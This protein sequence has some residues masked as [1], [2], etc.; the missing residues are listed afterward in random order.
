MKPVKLTMCAF[1]PYPDKKEVDLS[2]FGGCGL[3]LVTGDTGAGKTTIFDAISFALYGEASGTNRES[4]MFRSDF[5]LPETKTYV[6]LEFLYRGQTYKIERSPKYMKEKSRGEGT[7]LVNANATLIMPDSRVITGN[8][9]VNDEVKALIGIDKNQ[10]SQIAMIAQGD[11]LKLLLSSTDER[12]KIFRKVFNT[13][14][15]LKFQ[16]ELKLKAN[17]LKLQYEDLSKSILQYMNGIIC[18]EDS[19]LYLEIKELMTE[20]NINYLSKANELLDN[21]ICEDEI[22]EEKEKIFNKKIQEEITVQSTLITTAVANNSRL[23]RLTNSN[24][25]LEELEKLQD[26]YKRKKIKLVL[27]ENALYHIKPIADELHKS[28]KQVND[29]NISIS[30]HEEF[31]KHR[32]I[33]LDNLLNVYENEKLKEPKLLSLSNEITLVKNELEIYKD[34]E[35]LRKESDIINKQLYEKS[36]LLLDKK[37]KK[38]NI[39]NMQ[40]KIQEELISLKDI[41]VLAEQTKKQ[42]EDAYSLSEQLNQLKDLFFELEKDKETLISAQKLFLKSHEIS[43]AKS[44]EYEK[45]EQSFL[46]GQAGIIAMKLKDNIPCPVCGSIDHPLPAKITLAAPTEEELKKAK[47]ELL[48]AKEQA[49]KL[50]EKSSN[51]KVKV[52]AKIEAIIKYS[53]S[54]FGKIEINEIPELLFNETEKTNIIL[55]KTTKKLVEIRKKIEYK[56]KCELKKTEIEKLLNNGVKI[57]ETLEKEIGDLKV[58]QS[59]LMSRLDTIKGKIKFQNKEEAEEYIKIKLMELNNL[60]TSLENSEKQYNKCNGEIEKSK[61]VILDLNNRLVTSK[62]EMDLVIEK[63]NVTLKSRGFTNIDHYNDMLI[64]EDNI[65]SLKKDI[66]N[67][68]N[69][70]N[71]VKIDISNLKEETKNTV[72]INIEDS[73]KLKKEFEEQKYKSDK[74][75]N[76]IFSRL[77][78]NKKVRNEIKLKQKEMDEIEVEYLCY[79]NLSDTANGNLSGKQKI[80]FEYY[81]QSTYFN[82]II[83]EANRRF[84]YMTNGRFKLIIKEEP[85]NFRSQTGLELDVIDNYTGKSRSV[86]SLSGGESFK[87]SLSMA[88]GLSDMIQRFSGG[89]QIDTMFVDEGFGSLDSESLDQA[90]DVLNSLTNGDRLV[91]IISHVSELRERIDKKLIVKKDIS[92]SDIRLIV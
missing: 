13:D 66:E 86:K 91:G 18:S 40:I 48:D 62:A 57:I 25:R 7:T 6:E 21:L 65:I 61:A 42:K 54:L 38:N 14:V 78:N 90:I 85:N 46:T 45:L 32:T 37:E 60:K 53:Q 30:K 87:A 69:E 29:L 22:L 68:M 80:A 9:N 84:S 73:L 79:R 50:S 24:K 28:T 33:E 35:F 36:V 5:A 89:I 12:G 34:L 8:N 51:S 43:I 31:I 56:N 92:G 59:S 10:F 82:Q 27:C 19:H 16:H 4:I 11:F 75:F 74:K 1:G 70:V 63:L 77:K 47:Q 20:K 2:L 67:Y 17:S 88:L 26:E 23:E 72:Y 64:N 41:E 52:D 83:A 15:Y 81:V 49:Y 3:F 76:N 55:C 39:E 58:K 71:K 44:S